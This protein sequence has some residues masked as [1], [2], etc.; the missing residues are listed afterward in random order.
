[1]SS[2]GLALPIKPVVNTT[3]AITTAN[4]SASAPSLSFQDGKTSGFYYDTDNA[5]VHAAIDGVSKLS[6]NSTTLATDRSDMKTLYLVGT[7]V[8]PGSAPGSGIL[9]TATDNSYGLYYR[10]GYNDSRD[11]T[12][13]AGFFFE[14]K[15][16]NDTT[17]ALAT[18]DSQFNEVQDI[19]AYVVA[20]NTGATLASSFEIRGL[21]KNTDGTVTRVGA[22]STSN[23]TDSAWTATLAIS[24][25]QILLNVTG[26]LATTVRWKAHVVIRDS[27]T[28]IVEEE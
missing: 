6:L 25:T 26:A 10:A 21:Y 16:T 19:K 7:T 24:G 18:I 9:H 1:M 11:L 22:L 23:I 4:G 3:S 2:E 12:A 17:T 28:S 8:A 20:T 15:T 14:T 13:N 27:R 5:R